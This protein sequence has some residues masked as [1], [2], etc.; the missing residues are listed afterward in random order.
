MVKYICYQNITYC[1]LWVTVV[2]TSVT[3]IQSGQE[4]VTSKINLHK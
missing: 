3:L 2:P 4:Q 1:T